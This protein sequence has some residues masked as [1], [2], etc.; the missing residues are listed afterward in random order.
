MKIYNCEITHVTELHAIHSQWLD[1]YSKLADA[2]PFLRPEWIINW[3]K[4]FG[5]DNLR[6]VAFKD[7]QGKL[8]G[9]ALFFIYDSN[10]G[11]TLSLVGSGISDYSDILIEQECDRGVISSHL[12]DYIRSIRSQWDICD[13]QQLR[14]S[15]LLLT[16]ANSLSTRRLVSII[17]VCPVLKLP[18][19]ASELIPMLRSKKL[20]RNIRTG[21]KKVEKHGELKVE[22]ANDQTVDSFLDD[23]ISLHSFRWEMK[24]EAGIFSEKRVREFHRLAA[25]ELIKSGALH[26]YRFSL[27]GRLCAAYYILSHR[28]KSFGYIGGFDPM[29]TDLSLGSVCLYRIISDL[30]DSKIRLFDFLRGAENYKY[31]WGALNRYNYRLLLK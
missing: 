14:D 12:A 2:T 23:I 22:K 8:R 25:R 29:L 27:N 10:Y 15:S 13:F 28:E 18:E 7:V 24:E 4:V 11:R 30:I 17:D 26:L 9:L 16:K 20:R 3:W 5:N 31:S 19:K 21:I 1:L 6:G